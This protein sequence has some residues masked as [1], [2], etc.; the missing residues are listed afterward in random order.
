MKNKAIG[1][2][3][4]LMLCWRIDLRYMNQEDTHLNSQ[5]LVFGQKLSLHLDCIYPNQQ[6]NETT[7]IHEFVHN[8]QQAIQRAFELVRPN[9][10]EKQNGKM[11]PT[12]K[13]SPRPNIQRR[14]K[15]FTVSS[16]HR[17]WNNVR[18][19]KTLEGTVCH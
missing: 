9:L 11:L 6:E 16:N 10:N 13:K 7:D 14:T 17:R 2:G 8:R 15:S 19:R 18:S 3:N 5:F 1:H 4:C 12:I